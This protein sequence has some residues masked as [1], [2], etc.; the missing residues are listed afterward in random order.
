MVRVCRARTCRCTSPLC[1]RSAPAWCIALKPTPNL[2]GVLERWVSCYVVL[3]SLSSVWGA[4]LVRL[5]GLHLVA[6][7]AQSTL[8]VLDPHPHPYPCT[9]P[10]I[11]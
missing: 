11:F 3:S 9:Y 7:L 4:V 5:C 6:L 1:S 2:S 8:R 10:Y